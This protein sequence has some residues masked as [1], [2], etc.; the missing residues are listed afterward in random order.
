MA[1]TKFL[2]FVFLI[3][4]LYAAVHDTS[5]SS[6]GS[7]AG[8]QRSFD[9]P[10][11]DRESA[12]AAIMRNMS[13]ASALSALEHD[14]QA[15]PALVDSVKT[16]LA[17]TGS[18]VVSVRSHGDR[19]KQGSLRASS[20]QPDLT[21]TL[22]MFNDMIYKSLSKY[23]MEQA[24]CTTYYS[25][26]CAALE[27]ARGE[28]SAI[29]AA[30][31]A[32]KGKTL[33]AQGDV[34][35]ATKE[36]PKLKVELEQHTDSCAKQV[37]ATQ[38]HLDR[39]TADMKIM[40]T[41]LEKTECKSAF[42]QTRSLGLL[43][44]KTECAAKP[45]I[46]FEDSSLRQKLNQLGS[47]FAHQAVQDALVEL[48]GN[49]SRGHVIDLAQEASG[50]EPKMKK[51]KKLKV[52]K[53][54]MK[55]KPAPRT[56]PPADPCKDP[57][58]GLPSA[59]SKRGAKCTMS[60]SP[61]CG[62]MQN[63][64]LLVQA[65]MMDERDALK[66]QLSELEEKCEALEL[67]LTQQVEHA[68]SSLKDAQTKLAE[69]TSCESTA[70]EKGRLVNALQDELTLDMAKM[71]DTCAANYE[72]LLAE[73]CG[74]NKLRGEVLK[75]GGSDAMPQDCKLGKW[76]PRS[77]TKK[78]GGGTQRL[79]RKV[80]MPD[81][82]GAKCL[83]LNQNRTCND[84]PCPVDCKVATWSKWSS[85]SAQ[86]GGGVSQRA[87][88]VEVH[89]R[90]GGKSCGETTQAKSCNMH[91]CDKD[92]KLAAW[93]KWTPCSKQ[94]DGGTQR[95][96][97]FVTEKAT[98]D[99]KCADEADPTRLQY[100]KC[101]YKAC[102]KVPSKESP[103]LQCMSKVDVVLLLDGSRGLG[104]AG[105]R[106]TVEAAKLFVS[107]FK[108]NA[109]A[110]VAV[111]VFSGPS[112]WSGVSRCMGETSGPVDM[113]KDCQMT[114]A[115]HLSDDIDDTLA[116]LPSLTWPKGGSL[117]S[118]ALA[119]AETELLLARKD[120]QSVVVVVTDGRPLSFRR[121]GLAAERIKESARLVW[122]PVSKFAPLKKFKQWASRRWQENIVQ[123]S[124]YEKLAKPE[125]IDHIIANICP[126]VDGGLPTSKEIK[127]AALSK[128]LK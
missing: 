63:K 90:H 128:L 52:K 87:R 68:E 82:G 58:A 53:T 88:D 49:S 117:Q 12:K 83:P 110:R 18:R 93:T 29:S 5:Q 28:I 24:K 7:V 101:N 54:K 114:W 123:V 107:S 36:L 78:C 39:V 26:Q 106:K 27:S 92:C 56:M 126:V 20:S 72:G 97:K 1:T 95:R 48:A 121:T 47:D 21:S 23:D 2:S 33:S 30:A 14:S 64:F 17:A 109:D 103:T 69:A 41:I 31:A 61:S 70:A 62:K 125:A 6:N 99:G 80:M 81:K 67:T 84:K 96:S 59:A 40:A 37:N 4:P 15:P 11:E 8:M 122:V 71:K 85:C 75:L 13:V 44:C 35:L 74:L 94:C 3:H 38:K 45:F 51:T 91:A 73:Q 77:C 19:A 65:G 43:H 111:L 16:V 50:Q 57:D 86:C 108:K 34:D 46:A 89:M 105:W 66:E 9:P 32:C 22:A 116:K 102:K 115:S 79:A 55:K 10:E 119:S 42:V 100:K 98:G 120:S 104:E 113:A 76:E 60:D 25:K 124:S 127:K 118:L 112:S